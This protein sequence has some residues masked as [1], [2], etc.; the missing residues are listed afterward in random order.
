MVRFAGAAMMAVG[1]LI[2]TLCG[3]CT[4]YFSLSALWSVVGGTPESSYVW[5]ILIPALIFG[6]VPTFFGAWLFRSGQRQYRDA[7]GVRDPPKEG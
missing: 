6:G 1:G 7:A 2:V 3:S 5:I 4:A